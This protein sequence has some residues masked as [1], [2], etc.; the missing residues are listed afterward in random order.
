MIMI[1]HLLFLSSRKRWNQLKCRLNNQNA[2]WL[3]WNKFKLIF[4][5]S[6]VRKEAVQSLVPPSKRLIHISTRNEK[7]Q[8]AN[9]RKAYCC[10]LI[11]LKELGAKG[12]KGGGEL[13]T[14]QDVSVFRQSS[15][16]LNCNRGERKFPFPSIPENESLWFPFP[17]L[18]NVFFS[19]P[20]HSRH[21]EMFF[22]IP[23]PFV[24][25]GNGFIS[26]PSRSRICHS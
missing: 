10:L 24:N 13:N 18:G 6:F 25:C 9:G 14:S 17:N 22:F 5:W 20:S 2:Q 3:F 11:I 19:F 4:C 1:Y 7:S 26:F 21:L 23:F 12:S 8:E 15:I 16:R